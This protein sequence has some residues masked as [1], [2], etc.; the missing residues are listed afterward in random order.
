MAEGKERQGK[1]RSEK[2]RGEKERVDEPE[3]AKSRRSEVVGDPSTT[4][5]SYTCS[6]FEIKRREKRR[7]KVKRKG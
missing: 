4:K 5:M 2:R 7:G 1:R 6:T 3:V